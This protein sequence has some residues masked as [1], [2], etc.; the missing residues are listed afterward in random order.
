MRDLSSTGIPQKTIAKIQQVF[1]QYPVVNKVSHYGSRAKGN[2]RTGSDIDLV[3]MSDS[4]SYDQLITI[5]NELDD[6]L[7][8]YKIDL[9]LLEKI[10]NR[11]LVEH[12]HRV[13]IDFYEREPP[14]G[15]NLL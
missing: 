2:F 8:P 3:I 12:I 14:L 5:E 13:A 1:K 4:L 15:K 9:S 11:D 6:L 7:L 10:D